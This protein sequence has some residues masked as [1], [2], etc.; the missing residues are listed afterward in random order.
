MNPYSPG[1]VAMKNFVDREWEMEQLRKEIQNAREGRGRCILI[2]GEAGV[3]KSTFLNHF[4]DT[5]DEKC[6]VVSENTELYRDWFDLFDTVL[7]E[8][9]KKGKKFASKIKESGI[10]TIEALGA[11]S[12]KMAAKHIFGDVPMGKM[13]EKLQAEPAL[14]SKSQK[15]IAG[16]FR[17]LNRVLNALGK[18]LIII[19]DQAE[20]LLNI[21]GALTLLDL[22]SE[23]LSKQKY[24]HIIFIV[25]MRKEKIGDLYLSRPS[26]LNHFRVMELQRFSKEAAID[27]VVKPLQEEGIKIDF[28]VVSSVVTDCEFHP[29]YI[30]YFCYYLYESRKGDRITTEVWNS[31]R[32][33]TL[34]NIHEL[35]LA[36][37][38]S[39][40]A[41]EI[42]FTLAK[43]PTPLTTDS[44][45]EE[46][47]LPK[48][49]I[50]KEL[51]VLETGLI[52]KRIRF[53]I[54]SFSHTLLKEYVQSRF[55]SEVERQKY[56]IISINH[57]AQYYANSGE[58]D[59]AVPLYRSIV[60]ICQKAELSK[61]PQ[62]RD[63]Y[64][65][66]SSIASLM[67]EVKGIAQLSETE[68]TWRAHAG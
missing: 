10:R 65:K 66:A 57:V 19:L 2:V 58:Q 22:I 46:T 35:Q 17:K 3:G 26:L 62:I 32:M 33:N 7:K 39:S 18:S 27:A 36:S 63:I 51:K 1:I 41:K 48:E 67:P 31:I 34:D 15:I 30:Q 25:A 13:I 29:Y 4:Q 50:M 43:S 60:D 54:Y 55:L 59:S 24:S 52:I 16:E 56:T 12:L 28:D 38:R 64:E 6:L 44:I 49:I 37:V 47:K 8:G 9:A 68:V 11:I 5:N 40:E 23:D 14:Y 42:L 45:V 53:D 61:D 20:S 21:P